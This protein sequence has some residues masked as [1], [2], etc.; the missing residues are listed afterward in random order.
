M[1][2]IWTTI[3][4]LAHEVHE[5]RI[6]QIADAVSS[7][8][9]VNALGNINSKLGL[10]GRVASLLGRL[11]EEWGNESNLT[12]SDVATALRSAAATATY[13]RERETIDLV[14][15]G[16]KTEFVPTRRTEQVLLEL[17]ELAEKRIF[18]VSFVT[19]GIP[20]LEQALMDAMGRG[21]ELSILIER[22]E[23]EGGKLS[24]DP[25]A[26]LKANLPG[27]SLYVWPPENRERDQNGNFGAVHA[28][29][30]VADGRMAFLTSANLTGAALEKNMELGVL[31]KGGVIPM[32]VQRHF[33]ALKTTREIIEL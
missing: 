33:D 27:A 23:D 19:Y 32:A 3:A 9:D 12:P 21:V 8:A 26:K 15:T 14:W 2:G 22:G 6:A 24:F 1:T 4:E 11:V 31:I 13:A 28:K 5:D 18:L 29:C 7:V 20:V 17:I 16:P 30:A 10:S 25:V